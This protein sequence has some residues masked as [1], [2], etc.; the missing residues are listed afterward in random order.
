MC[1]TPWP[2]ALTLFT[3]EGSRRWGRETVYAPSVELRRKE[4]P[5]TQQNALGTCSEH[6]RTDPRCGWTI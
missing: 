4:S 1:G 2:A 3:R 6:F 5:A